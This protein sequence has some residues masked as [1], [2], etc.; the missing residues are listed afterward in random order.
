MA[1]QTIGIGSSAND[2]TGDD[3]RTAGDKINDNFTELYS[4]AGL[5]TDSAVVST[6]QTTTTTSYTDLS[7]SG[8]AVTVTT[9]TRALVIFG[10]GITKTIASLGN[11]GYMSFAVSGATTSAA[12]DTNSCWISYPLSTA[13]FQFRIQR[14]MLVTGLT[15]GSNTFTAKYRVDGS[16]F[17]F[18]NRDIAVIPLP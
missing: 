14:A 16:T 3:L 2:G 1:Q 17:E 15:A 12:S 18:R 11:S 7:T 10:C 13:N 9:G 5:G 4:A 6:A 8:P